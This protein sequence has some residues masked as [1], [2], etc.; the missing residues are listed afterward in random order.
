MNL[1]SHVYSPLLQPLP[2]SLQLFP[3]L[4]LFS[5]LFLFIFSP[6][7]LYFLSS[8]SLP[9]PSTDSYNIYDCLEHTLAAENWRAYIAVFIPIL[10]PP[11]GLFVVWFSFSPDRITPTLWR[12]WPASNSCWRKCS[13][14]SE[15]NFPASHVNVNLNTF[16]LPWIPDRRKNMTGSS[17]AH[18]T[19][20]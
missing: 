6:L 7:F 1:F 17:A 8:S 18:H 13:L 16:Y 9:K 15:T 10:T 5:S 3:I 11:N 2:S 19:F 4:L 14:E 12:Q 20:Y